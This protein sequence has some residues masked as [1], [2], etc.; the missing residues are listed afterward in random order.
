MWLYI[1]NMTIFNQQ[2]NTCFSCGMGSNLNNFQTDANF[3]NSNSSSNYSS[4]ASNKSLVKQ[5]D[6]S[7]KK[8]HRGFE[9]YS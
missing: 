4:T 1:K 2:T 7:Q 9:W 3:S 6:I 5:V 8:K